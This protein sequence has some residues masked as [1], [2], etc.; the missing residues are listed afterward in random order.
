MARIESDPNYT[1]P[2]FS[3]ATAGTDPFK[4]GDVQLLASAMST[5]VHDGAGKGLQVT[6][7]PAAAIPDNAVTSAKIL[8]GAVT[9][10]KIL[11]GT[12]ATADLAGHSISQ[13]SVATG[14]TNNPTTTSGA[15]VDVPEMALTMTTT[16]GDVLAWFTTAAQ[17]TILSAICTFSFKVDAGGNVFQNPASQPASTSAL[18]AVSLVGV[19]TGLSAGSH[20][21]KVQW[22]TNAGTLQAYA[23]LRYLI[24]VEL[25]K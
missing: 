13:T 19:F 10:A 8:D 15:F 3:R 18:C 21:F 24:V 9:S 5:H 1:T 20:T 17:P 25:K 22:A 11:D 23:T 4:M 2:T 14:A 7:I 12:I 16:G 6:A